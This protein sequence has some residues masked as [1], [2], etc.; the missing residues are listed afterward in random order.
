MNIRECSRNS[1]FLVMRSLSVICYSLLLSLHS[2]NLAVSSLHSPT[3]KI[4]VSPSLI[5]PITCGN[6][7]HALAFSISIASFPTQKFL[8]AQS[9]VNALAWIGFGVL[10]IHVLLLWLFIIEFR[11]GIPG[12]AL[13]YDITSRGIASAEKIIRQTNFLPRQN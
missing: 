5:P 2:S 6:T 1:S 7:M 3:F 4:P 10:I 9:K 12:A 13:A 8:Q 11:W